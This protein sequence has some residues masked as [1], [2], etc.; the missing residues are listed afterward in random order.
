MNWVY[1]YTNHTTS[2][3]ARC[4]RLVTSIVLFLPG[5]P[6]GAPCV[7]LC[8]C[9][10]CCRHSIS[11]CCHLFH[12]SIPCCHW[13]SS[14]PSLHSASVVCTD[15]QPPKKALDYVQDHSPGVSNE[16]KTNYSLFQFP[17][18]DAVTV[19]PN[20]CVLQFTTVSKLFLKIY[21]LLITLSPV[22]FPGH[23][24]YRVGSSW[25]VG[26]GELLSAAL[27]SRGGVI[28]HQ[29]Q[30]SLCEHWPPASIRL[31]CHQE[32][33]R[34]HLSIMPGGTKWP[35]RFLDNHMVRPHIFLKC[36]VIVSFS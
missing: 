7:S 15:T 30:W 27:V 1:K 18:L 31:K 10:W 26:W 4:S 34:S 14:I 22:P 24:L 3:A 19:I 16:V 29:A 21:L 33:S 17:L 28:K 12:M 2:N 8:A 20:V 23:E 32:V 6:P 25:S 35:V 11:N 5:H 9:I 36:I 13:L